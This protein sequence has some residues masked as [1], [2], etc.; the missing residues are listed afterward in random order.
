MRSSHSEVIHKLALYG[1]DPP[2]VFRL[3]V[4]SRSKGSAP[5]SSV[6]KN[7]PLRSVG[8]SGV[9][10]LRSLRMR[11]ALV[12]SKRESHKFPRDVLAFAMEQLRRAAEA[13]RG[14]RIAT[15]LAALAKG[16][17]ERVKW[18]SRKSLRGVC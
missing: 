18:S 1:V 3:S 7:V 2:H 5:V 4:D 10:Q 13:K 8:V 17:P 6:Q 15:R 11:S 12:L 16:K 9:S 14:M